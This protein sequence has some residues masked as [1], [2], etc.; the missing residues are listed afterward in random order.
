MRLGRLT[1]LAKL[2]SLR[3]DSIYVR[4]LIFLVYN[5]W[6]ET[7]LER[8]LSDHGTYFPSYYFHLPPLALF[9]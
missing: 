6:H 8:W 2:V 9:S 1:G 3:V 5:K 7:E 4:D